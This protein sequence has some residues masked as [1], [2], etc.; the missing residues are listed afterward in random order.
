MARTLYRIYL[1][2][3]FTVLL[4]FAAF[5][6]S[7]LL[8][9]LLRFTGLLGAF[10]SAPSSSEVVQNIVLAAI[11]LVVSLALG[12]L[13]YWLIRRDIAQDPGAARGA[14]RSL[15]L[16]LAQAVAALVAFFAGAIVLQ[17]VWQ[18]DSFDVSGALAATLVAAAVFALEQ[19]ERGR[20]AP[21]AGVPM[22]LQRL[23]LYGVQV[24]VL[25]ASIAYWLSA[26]DTTVRAILIGLNL[27]PNP[28]LLLRAEQQP[29]GFHCDLTSQLLGQWLAV[30]WAAAAWGLYTW[31]ARGDTRSVLRKVAQYAGFIAGLISSIVGVERAAELALRSAFGLVYD[32]P[33]ALA[34]DFDFFP[35]LL[36]GLVAMVVYGI[37][38]T[39]E[40]PATPLGQQGTE[41]TTMALAAVVLGVPFYIAIGLLLHGFV[42]S[43]VTGAL[44]PIDSFAASLALLIS[45]LAHP[46][47]AFELR[48]RTTAD[49]PI[50]PRRGFVLAGLAAGALAGVIGGA[51]ALYLLITAQFGSPVS[52][53]WPVN[54]RT[55][56]VVFLVG[57][58]VAGIHLW[59]TIAERSLVGR[60]TP[61]VPSAAGQPGAIE[62]VLDELLAGRITREQAA[63]IQALTHGE[64]GK[65]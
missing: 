5:S 50:G 61:A 54:A 39:T 27:I 11:A 47:I 31:L 33:A 52:A 18:P 43:A 23:H 34:S 45:G 35:A 4:G 58:F 57:G 20:S 12:G 44:Y 46:F 25:L 59:R 1:Y 29:P 15:F 49:V 41:L 9:T 32:F 7:S 30:L 14:V 37:W 13:H 6:L 16:N 56:A 26:I 36:F 10:E 3:V 48:R 63:R 21:A 2:L 24:I 62:S 38:L 51:I 65:P 22:V 8:S 28:C 42:E 19:I 17:Q 64:G 55:D 40:A 60:P 53:D